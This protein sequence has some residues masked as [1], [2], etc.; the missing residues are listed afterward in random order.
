M[1]CIPISCWIFMNHTTPYHTAFRCLTITTTHSILCSPKGSPPQDLVS[2]FIFQY[3][4]EFS[5]IIPYIFS[6]HTAF[7]CYTIT[8]HTGQFHFFLIQTC[9]FARQWNDGWTTAYGRSHTPENIAFHIELA[10]SKW[11]K[12]LP[13]SKF[14]KISWMLEHLSFCLAK[15]WQHSD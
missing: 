11:S 8:I 4:A 9:P 5:W 14:L 6:L 10:T 1:V 13:N 2:W 3:H 7:R 15:P 12:W